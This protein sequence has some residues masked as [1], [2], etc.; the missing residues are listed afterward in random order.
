MRPAAYSFVRYIIFDEADER[1]PADK[2]GRLVKKVAEQPVPHRK[3]DPKPADFDTLIFRAKTKTL[4][5]E[6]VVLFDVGKHI[7]SR[8]EH[9]LKDGD[10]NLVSVAAD[11]MQWTRVAMVPRLG[12]AG[13][14]DGSSDSLSAQSAASRIQSIFRQTIEYDF[15]HEQT[16]KPEDVRRAIERLGLT[17]FAFTVVP[18]NPHPRNP[19]AKLDELMKA[20]KIGRL[21]AEATP[22]ASGLMEASS[23]GLISEAMGL[24]ESGYGQ[25]GFKGV[26]KSSGSR[27]SYRKPKL[28][29]TR[30]K[31]L[32]RRQEPSEM[33]ASIPRNDA[34]RSED[35]H[36][37]MTILEM[38]DDEASG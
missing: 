26:V 38:F 36:V 23:D 32:A 2:H 22:K 13:I 33:R 28:E 29:D 14:R 12:I 30:E 11:D 10:L 19:G 27:V 16:G 5:D 1:V 7:T 9:R 15:S 37:V 4:C 6:P 34:K 18:F 25:L 31:N 17:D 8:V 20:S 24:A 21:K 35:E 3:R